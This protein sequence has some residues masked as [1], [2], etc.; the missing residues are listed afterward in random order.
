MLLYRNFLT[1]FILMITGLS[2][3]SQ[4]H[5]LKIAFSKIGAEEK[6]KLYPQWLTSMDQNVD[7]VDMSGIKSAD[8]AKLLESCSGL[9]L[10]GGPDIFP[11]LYKKDKDLARCEK[12]DRVRDSEEI[13]LI[14][15]ALELKI[16][17]FAICRGAQL[18]NVYHGGTLIIDIS[19]D[20]GSVVP[21]RLSTP[22]GAE[23]PVTIEPK[24][25]FAELLKVKDGV[26]NSFH[27]Q[28]VEKLAPVF[29]PQAKS[30][31]GIVE[32]FTWK[33][34]AGKSFLIAVQWHPERM[35]DNALFSRKLAEEF[36]VQARNYKK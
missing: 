16:P 8:A 33:E 28:A 12:V 24:S 21:H 7:P 25:Y 31:D 2:S 17:I 1:V 35:T 30:P 15:K 32:A 26:V 18:L 20:Y 3:M 29:V 22:K 36:L 10:T 34:P 9:V 14:K 11:G 23:H 19:G 27:H 5:T 13:M 4:T 6:Y